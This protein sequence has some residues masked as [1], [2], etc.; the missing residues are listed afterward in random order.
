MRLILVQ[1]GVG[2]EAKLRNFKLFNSINKI[3][4]VKNYSRVTVERTNFFSPK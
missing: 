3:H 4:G 2:F 1:L